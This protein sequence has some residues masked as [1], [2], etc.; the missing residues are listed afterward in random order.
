MTIALILIVVIGA[1]VFF[2]SKGATKPVEQSSITPP[3]AEQQAN[4][5]PAPP[6][7][8]APKMAEVAPAAAPPPAED[9]NQNLLAA[10]QALTID[11][12]AAMQDRVIGNAS[13]PVTITEYASMTCP[14]CAHFATE[15]LPQVKKLLIDTGRAKLIFRDFPLDNFALKAAMMARCVPAD[16]YFSLV[17]VIFNNQERWISNKDP[18]EGLAQLGALAG[19]DADLFNACTQNK[20]LETAI[21]NIMNDGQSRYDI[22]STPTFVFNNGAEVLGGAQ[23]AAKFEE[24]VNKLTRGK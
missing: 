7:A 17:E 2:L 4:V 11:L 10:P 1:L 3:A 13:A 8:E 22:K 23:D 18:L 12:A 14:H 24:I 21:L 16:K 6:A 20:T 19:M 9:K 5:P 15:I